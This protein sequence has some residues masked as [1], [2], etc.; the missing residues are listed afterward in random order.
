MTPT[1][2]ISVEP[3]VATFRPLDLDEVMRRLEGRLGRLH[4]KLRLGMEREHEQQAFGQGL[5]FLHIENM[6]L[7]QVT[8]E[9]LLRATGTYWRGRANAS[10]VSLRRNDVH[11]G[12]L[13]RAFDGFS[14]L[15]LSDLHADMSAPALERVHRIVRDLHYDL[16]VL[17]G[18]F[19]GRTF[20]DY[21]P[22]I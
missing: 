7:V 5:T 20:G 6:P 18:D 12:H 10:K 13:S 21:R 17:T 1:A 22:S 8:I 3:E 14:L 2:E 15:H 9:A 16:C 19:R 4:A 11:M